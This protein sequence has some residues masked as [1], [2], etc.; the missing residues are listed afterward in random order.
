MRMEDERRSDNVE[1]RRRGGRVVGGGVG[2]VV[3][4][5]LAWFVTGDPSALINGITG[6]SSTSQG[7]STPQEEK[8]ADFSSA[9]LASTE[10]VWTDLFRGM[11]KTYQ[12][13]KMVLFR[14]AVDSA[15]GRASSAVGPFYCP[16]DAKLYLDL[17]F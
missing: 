1:D 4:G 7:P 3:I 15:C 5:L 10:D 8:L 6:G 9:V 2:V 11:G 12:K 17:G 13:P 16:G 14:G